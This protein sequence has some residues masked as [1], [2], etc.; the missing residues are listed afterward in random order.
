MNFGV[1]EHSAGP[2]FWA[3]KFALKFMLTILVFE[4]KEGKMHKK[5]KIII[6]NNLS[7]LSVRKT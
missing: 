5:L 4:I 3:S 2:F 1:V 6:S 7:L